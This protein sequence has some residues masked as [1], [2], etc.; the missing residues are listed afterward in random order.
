MRRPSPPAAPDNS[1]PTTPGRCPS[2]D[3]R[4][5]GGLQ[6]SPPK[7]HRSNR[8]S[9][10]ECPARG[11]SG[12]SPPRSVGANRWPPGC[13]QAARTRS[14][15]VRRAR[16]AARVKLPITRRQR[17]RSSC[18]RLRCSPRSCSTRRCRGA[19]RCQRLVGVFS[20]WPSGGWWLGIRLGQFFLSTHRDVDVWRGVTWGVLL[21][22]IRVNLSDRGCERT[23]L[24]PGRPIRGGCGGSAV[25]S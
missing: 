4:Q 2:S 14:R 12:Y 24:E 23:R 21:T 13:G 20:R 25:W 18:C 10:G 22:S 7:R 19:S 3:N 6:T 11:T 8:M 9:F 5:P 16:A 1:D 17:P 15:D